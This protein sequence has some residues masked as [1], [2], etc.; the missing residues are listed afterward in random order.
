MDRLF[1]IPQANKNQKNFT[2]NFIKLEEGKIVDIKNVV[3]IDDYRL[4]IRFNDDTE[5]IVDFGN[6]LNNSLN[7]MIRKYLDIK[8]FKEFTVEYGDLLWND[9]DLCF[10][11][12]DLYENKI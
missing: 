5:R 3:Y 7:P 4:K 2:K 6:F 11:I 9:Y 12:A 1:C 10:P 8:K